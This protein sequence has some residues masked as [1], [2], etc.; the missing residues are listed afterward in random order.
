MAVRLTGVAVFALLALPAAAQGLPDP[1]RP[2]AAILA[3]TSGGSVAAP[4]APRLTSVILPRSGARPAAIIDGTR[5]ELGHR[6]DDAR[7]VAID[8]DAVLLEGPNGRLKLWLTPD[9][10]KHPAK[11]DRGN[12]RKK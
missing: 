11:P 12:K 6:L 1:T 5:V 2:P 9:A 7:L 3:A 4:A 10:R 8:E